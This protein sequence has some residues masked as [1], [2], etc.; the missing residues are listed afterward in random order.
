MSAIDSAAHVVLEGSRLDLPTIW[1][2]V[3]GDALPDAAI[4][5][6][7]KRVFVQIIR[8]ANEVSNAT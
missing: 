8:A 4:E 1:W 3:T 6:V 5:R 7:R 2:Q